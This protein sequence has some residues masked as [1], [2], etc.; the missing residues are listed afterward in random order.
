MTTNQELE[1]YDDDELEQHEPNQDEPLEDRDIY[2]WLEDQRADYY[3]AMYE[4]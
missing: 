1:Y 4:F 2:R 3:T